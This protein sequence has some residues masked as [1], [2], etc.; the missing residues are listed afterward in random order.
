LGD[1]VL[2]FRQRND[3]VDQHAAALA[4]HGEHGDAKRPGLIDRW[5]FQ[6]Q[7]IQPASSGEA[8][9]APVAAT[10]QEADDA[11]TQLCQQLVEARRVVD[12]VGAVE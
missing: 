4:A 11:A 8:D 6:H 10:L 5:R 12:D 3:P 1:P 7:I 2:A 9:A